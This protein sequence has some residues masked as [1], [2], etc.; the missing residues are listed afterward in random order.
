ML[1]ALI[2][3]AAVLGIF[4]GVENRVAD[5]MFELSLFRIRAFTAGNLASL[6]SAIGRG[7]LMFV[8]IIWLQGI[9]L[10]RHGYS[11]ADTP[12][13]AGIYMLPLTAGFLVAGPISGAI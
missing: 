2:G 12:L 11:F 8:L 13:W 1:A 7:G 10:P 9:W 5:P 6:L 4:V 3:G